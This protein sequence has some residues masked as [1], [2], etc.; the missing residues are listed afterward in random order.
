MKP[1]TAGR[2][3]KSFCP[4]DYRIAPNARFAG[5]VSGAQILTFQGEQR[6]DDLSAGDCVLTR[7]GAVPILRIDVVSMVAPTV[8]M[9]AG[10]LGHG[11]RDTDALLTA[12]QTVCLRDWRAQAFHGQQTAL[13][14]ARALVDGEF[15]RNL[16]QQ[17]ITLHRIFCAV[18]QVFYA[19]GLEMGT[20]DATQ[21]DLAH[22]TV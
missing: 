6:V 7:R 20:A 17:V 2:A 4:P 9:M 18:P 12:D 13:V 19:D 15:V 11:R 14:P 5:L 10:T 8:Y 22:H 3:G 16:G 1:K 21:L